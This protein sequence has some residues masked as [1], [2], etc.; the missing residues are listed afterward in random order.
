[1]DEGD[2]KDHCTAGTKSDS[3][4]MSIPTS[5]LYQDVIRISYGASV[6]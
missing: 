1:V 2:Q 6:T 3:I 4:H 5:Q